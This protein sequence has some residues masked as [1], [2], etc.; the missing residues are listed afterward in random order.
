MEFDYICNSDKTGNYTEMFFRLG[1]GNA[2]FTY[3]IDDV[4]IEGLAMDSSEDIIIPAIEANRENDFRDIRDNY[5]RDYIDVLFENNILNGYDAQSFMPDEKITANSIDVIVERVSEKIKK[6]IE[7]TKE[8]L[9]LNSEMSRAEVAEKVFKQMQTINQT[10]YYVDSQLGDDDNPATFEKPLKTIEKARQVVKITSKNMHENLYVFLK[11]GDYKITKALQFNEEDSGKNGYSIIYKG[12][13]GGNSVINGG[14]KINDW[15]I[16][17]ANKNIFRAPSK[18]IQTRQLFVNGERAVRARSV[19]GL[20]NAELVLDYGF[21]TTDTFLADYKIPSDLEFIFYGAWTGQRLKVE[22]INV[23]DG[24]ANIVFQGPQWKDASKRGQ[25]ATDE[26]TYYENAYELIDEPGEWYLDKKANMF[27]YKPR[28]GENMDTANVTAPIL[29]SLMEVTGSYISTPVRNLQFKNISFEYSTWL[30]PNKFGHLHTQNN[31]IVDWSERIFHVIPQAAVTVK[32]ARN[33]VF[34]ACT[35]AHLGS[36]TLVLMDGVQDSLVNANTIYDTSGGGIHI[37]VANDDPGV[38]NPD[39]DTLMRNCNVTNNHIQNIGIDYPSA[40][41]ISGGFPQDTEI[42]HNEIY[43]TPYSGMHFNFGWELIPKTSLKNFKIT[44]NIVARTNR[45]LGDGGGIYVLGHTGGTTENPNI[46]SENYLF[47]PLGGH[48]IYPDAGSNFWEI[49]NNVFNYADISIRQGKEENPAWMFMWW[50][51]LKDITASNNYVTVDKGVN[52]GTGTTINNT[53][54]VPDAKWDEKAL[55]II[56]KAG[57]LPKYRRYDHTDLE[58]IKVN[59]LYYSKSNENINLEFEGKDY[60]GGIVDLGDAQLDINSA[61][62]R[63]V[64]INYLKQLKAV[65]QGRTFVN[66]MVKKGKSV[67]KATTEILVDDEL[68]RLDLVAEKKELFMGNST[69]IKVKGNTLY[70]KTVELEKISYASSDEKVAVVTDTGVLKSLLPG[71]VNITIVG[72]YEG[73]KKSKEVSFNILDY[74]DKSVTNLPT[75]NFGKDAIIPENWSFINDG[76]NESVKKVVDNKIS[77]GGSSTG[78]Y[79]GFFSSRKFGNELL[80]FTYTRDYEGGWPSIIFRA[81]EKKTFTENGTSCYI[82]VIKDDEMELQKFVN[83][84]RTVFYGKVPGF[85]SLAGPAYPNGIMP[86]NTT[87]KIQVGAINKSEG[88]QLILNIDGYN[89]FSAIDKDDSRITSDGYFSILTIGGTVTI[90]ESK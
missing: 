80:E 30:R 4:A 52:N 10:A 68:K 43:D 33:I 20:S 11:S 81:Q 85:E 53:T 35:F 78:M 26:V 86:P 56:E 61:D 16:Y 44:N 19:G 39:S 76:N 83:G 7:D 1:D 89:I 24:M 9:A 23:K 31:T 63:I 37:G 28:A 65:S 22:S 21:K 15:Q 47:D 77:L 73:I 82:I 51:G 64:S 46:I 2:A 71:K 62:N 49:D 87:H 5:A 84:K 14:E 29:E 59:K 32:K 66:A 50:K 40:T 74:G 88:V 48:G 90:G 57:I 8:L 69:K 72:E 79:E 3:Y 12:V 75:Y 17:D 13:N 70:G 36:E 34:E 27:Y 18:G 42:S 58:T 55:E 67:V 41:A 25:E 45:I 38:Y 6:S 60:I 54:V